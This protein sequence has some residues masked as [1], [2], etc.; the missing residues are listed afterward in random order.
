MGILRAVGDAPARDIIEQA[1]SALEAGSVVA[2]PTDTVYALVADVS[3]TGV[4][5]RLFAMKRRPRSQELPVIVADMEQAL[6]ITIG[7][8]EAAIVLMEKFWPGPLTIVLP[9]HPD[10]V[11]DLGVDD[12]ETVGVRCPGHVIPRT[13]CDE[14]G[15]LAITTANVQGSSHP[16]TT[17]QQ[18][19][20]RFGDSVE[21]ILDGGTCD[22]PIATVVDCTGV[23]PKLLREGAIAWSA[24]A[25]ATI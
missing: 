25:N 22:G 5:D 2:V 7:V 20:D 16:A 21:V 12:T 24:I 4:A 18:V 19:H 13:L 10:Y 11:A 1:A 6:S 9:R 23:E 15:P 17:A 3:Y 8:P 14:V